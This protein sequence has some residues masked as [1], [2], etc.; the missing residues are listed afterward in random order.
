MR[1]AAT[2]ESMAMRIMADACDL[3]KGSTMTATGPSATVP[4]WPN[5][6]ITIKRRLDCWV[7]WIG[8]KESNPAHTRWCDNKAQL[9]EDLEH[10][11]QSGTLPIES[12]QYGL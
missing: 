3:P 2:P 12:Q 5:P 4:G 8:E 11:A 1:N 7:M 6:R 10:F 9:M